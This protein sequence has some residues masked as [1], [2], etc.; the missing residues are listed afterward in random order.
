LTAAE[1]GNTLSVGML[2]RDDDGPAAET[3]AD[4]DAYVITDRADR[5]DPCKDLAR[6]L[7]APKAP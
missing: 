3:A 5:A 4:F 2:E 7:Q 1:R 6:Q